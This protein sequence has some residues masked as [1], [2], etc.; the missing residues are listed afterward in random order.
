MS[1][2]KNKG[3]GRMTFAEAKQLGIRPGVILFPAGI[4]AFLIIL[5]F[6]DAEAFITYLEGV[7]LG[8]MVNFGWLINTTVLMF[9]IFM[10]VCIFSPIG[11]IKFGG[12]DAKPEFNRWNW[13]AMSLIAGIGTG[14]VMWGP[15]EPLMLSMAPAVGAGVEPGTAGAVMW[16]MEKSFLHWTFAPY[17][18][19]MSAAVVAGYAFYNMKHRFSISTAFAPLLGDRVYNPKFAGMVDAL[20]VF[21]IVGGTAGSLGFGLMQVGG[22]IAYIAGLATGPVMWGV[23][24]T[25]IIMAYNATSVSGLHR[26]IKKTS[27]INA[28]IFIGLM[29]MVFIFGP[30]VFTLNLG[31]MASGHFFQNFLTSITFTFPFHDAANL[32]GNTWPAG[33]ELWPQWWD[34][35]WFADWLS[36]GPII[37]LFLIKL[38]KGRT[39]RE[40]VIMSWFTPAVFAMIWFTIFGS[41]ALDIQFNPQ[42]YPTVDLIG[43]GTLH[44]YMQAHGHE[45]VMLKVLEAM[46]L[47]NIIRPLMLLIVCLSFITMADGI[48]STISFMSVKNSGGVLKEA[49]IQLKLGWGIILGLTAYIFVLTGGL[50]GIQVV[51]TMAGFPIMF[52]QGTIVVGF[53]IYM[54]KRSMSG[55]LEKELAGALPGEVDAAEDKAD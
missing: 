18:I 35:F 37:G 48:T 42:N 49:P 10:L 2:E 43:Y 9:V 45:M 27:S 22:G 41:L 11:K 44:A 24:A 5:G 7:F 32:M 30:T 34:M 26:G 3:H 4:F 1:D 54:I 50:Q 47:A 14:I 40:F 36:F 20:V 21:A 38:A 52:L 28:Y 33:S 53:L 17:A 16:A 31:T 8:I 25:I 55:K 15:V 39:I 23:I 12:K 13:W 51:K 46:P 6:F 29:V 19:Y